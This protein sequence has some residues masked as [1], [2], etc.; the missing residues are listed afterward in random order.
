M[1]SRLLSSRAWLVTVFLF[2]SACLL[3]QPAA[4]T[5]HLQEKKSPQRPANRLAKESSPYLLQ[6][7]HNPVDWFPWCPEAFAK[8]K[9]EN[10]LIFLSI[11][12][13]SCHWCHVM[14]RESF[15]NDEV[16]KLMNRSFVCIKVDREERPD[17]DTVYMTALSAQG[18]RGGWPLS[19]F[20]T[21]DGKPIVGG[22]Y[23][24]AEDKETPGGTVR[25]FKSVLLLMEE[26]QK[27]EPAKLAAQAAKLAEFTREAL[28]Q[29]QSG[30]V[31]G[32]LDR[33][34]V[35]ATAK[36]LEEEF[37]PKFGGFGN[38]AREFAGSKFP[39]PANLD[40][41]LGQLNRGAREK[42]LTVLT[43]SLDQMIQGGINDQIEGGF[44]RYSTERTWT[45]PHFE[46]MLYDNGQLLEVYARAYALT[47]KPAYRRCALETA[48]FL[49]KRLTSPEGSFYASLDADTEG[50]EGRTY[51]WS[52]EQISAAL[53]GIPNATLFKEVYGLNKPGNFEDKLHILR[54]EKSIEEIGTSKSIKEPEL[55][56]ML[57][58]AKQALKRVRDRR[59]QPFL[60]TKVLTCWNGLA[61][62]GLAA[63]GKALNEPAL[64][65]R[66][67]KAA[68]LLLASART[69][70][71]GLQRVYEGKG[72]SSRVPGYLDDYTHFV[73]GLLC[74]HEATG[75]AKWLDAARTLTDRM[76]NLFG[77]KQAG[78]FFY[79]SGE[80]ES[81]FARSKDQFDGAMP[82][83][84]SMAAR[85]LVQLWR[86]TGDAKYRQAADSTLK[87][88]ALTLKSNPGG[89]VTMA[90]ALADFLDTD[91]SKSPIET[92]ALAAPLDGPTRSDSVVKV[93][94]NVK[95][96]AEGK[97]ELTIT[98][99]IDK[100]WHLYANPPG[101]D[102]FVPS[103]T[104]MT[105]EAKKPLGD[106]NIKY[107]D[108]KDVFD[109]VLGRY[110]VYE[111][112]VEL[113]ATFKRAAGDTSPL[114]VKLKFQSCNDKTCLL[115]GTK[116]LS[117]P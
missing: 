48:D 107:P 16:A 20:L 104:T 114:E 112:K 23:W 86:L 38:K 68:D 77:D 46:K 41:I 12:Y 8:A 83:G 49:R 27:K 15:A 56:A 110:K 73:H 94:S 29:A 76:L 62:A 52:D 92:V 95:A 99:T 66:A 55:A 34:I 60:D 72:K 53:E 69:E 97:Q 21:P 116:T 113:K 26:F 91:K 111:D 37:D 36:A 2:A 32:D 43:Q 63:A 24:P 3:V 57:S 78:G 30:K 115:P 7:A 106:L 117:V 28:A 11:G 19:M 89:A 50:V 79:S 59:P 4:G 102:D 93:A 6:H 35:D 100:G 101:Q 5:A 39:M 25:G 75:D 87:S 84:N 45:V 88:C 44:H 105:V 108:G 90:A 40:F 96:L 98:L 31:I 70:K 1:L 58:E 64:I 103:Q 22:T 54:L 17:I 74:L 71:V 109:Q 14:E 47:G 10:K 42:L 82:S 85:N 65:E 9:S 80:H 18:T 51:V 67:G 13:S 61:I 81:L 33:R